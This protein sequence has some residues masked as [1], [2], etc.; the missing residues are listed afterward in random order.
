MQERQGAVKVGCW[1]VAILAPL[2]LLFFVAVANDWISI[3]VSSA[4]PRRRDSGP[5]PW[6]L[7]GGIA[8][9]IVLFNAALIVWIVRRRRAKAAS[10]AQ[11]R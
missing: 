1:L 8:L 9:L 10:S 11:P 4:P 2:A 7:M 5:F 6:L 3:P